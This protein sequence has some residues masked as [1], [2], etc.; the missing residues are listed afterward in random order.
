[1]SLRSNRL[2]GERPHD[3]PSGRLGVPQRDRRHAQAAGPT[4][5]TADVNMGRLSQN[6]QFFPYGTNTAIVAPVVASDALSLP[7]QSLNTTSVVLAVTSRPF[8]Y[9]HNEDTYN[10]TAHGLQD[11]SYDTY[12]GEV[13]VSPG[14]LIDNFTTQLQDTVGQHLSTRARQHRGRRDHPERGQRQ[15]PPAGRVGG[16]HR[17]SEQDAHGGHLVRG[18]QVLRRGLRGA[19]EHLPGGLLP[20]AQRRKRPRNRRVR[21]AYLP[22][23]TPATPRARRSAAGCAHGVPGLTP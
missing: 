6:A 14:A 19:A 5:I 13:T 10:E 7:V 2:S 22:L 12:T 1:M 21:S 20:R 4:R 9:L 15:D 3:Q 11:A 16:L 18:L 17:Q 23:V 8:T